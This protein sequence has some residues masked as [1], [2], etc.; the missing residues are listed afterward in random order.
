LTA[1]SLPQKST[2]YGITLKSEVLL[3]W[4]H[5]GR[6]DYAESS[7]T[8]K[9]LSNTYG[10]YA[11]V[12][13]PNHSPGQQILLYVGKAGGIKPGQSTK[14]ANDIRKRVL[15]KYWDNGLVRG[16][17]KI[18]QNSYHVDLWTIDLKSF[19]GAVW[20]RDIELIENT[21][22]R[23]LKAKNTG[24]LPGNSSFEGSSR[25]WFRVEVVDTSASLPNI[26][27][28]PGITEESHKPTKRT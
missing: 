12:L 6:I 28:L 1:N 9:K 11:F 13:V 4:K 17:I 10:L 18:S 22:I 24:T 23:E 16:L 20:E 2:F 15:Q 5:M 7:D 21:F 25:R 19:L 8:L 26:R 3:K 14:W 27:L